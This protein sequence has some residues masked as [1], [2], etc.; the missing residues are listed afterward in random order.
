MLYN[1]AERELN[2]IIRE[3]RKLEEE[4][5]KM[6]AGALS[7]ARN[8]TRYK[9]YLCMGKE[10]KYIPKREREFAQRL[11]HKKYLT[12]RLRRFRNEEKALKSYLKIHNQNTRQ[13]DQDLLEHPEFQKLLE[14]YVVNTDEQ[15]RRWMN[16]PVH[17]NELHPEHLIHNTNVGNVVRSKSESMI[18]T[19]LLKHK[20]PFRYEETIVLRE[21][22]IRPDF[23][24]IHPKTGEIII[25]EHVGKM[26]DE[27][28][29]ADFMNKFQKYISNKFVPFVNLVFTCETKECPLTTERIEDIIEIVYEG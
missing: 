12:L 15:L 25:W 14:P 3:I 26:D 5:K 24:T 16:A 13:K 28:Y 23:V 10:I 27:G 18:E 2:R 17:N 11:A 1:R 19:A 7:C 9:W 29:V 8:G 21:G 6:P 4:L 20:I 22:L